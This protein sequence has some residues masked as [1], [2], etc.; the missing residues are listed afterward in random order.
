MRCKV[1]L[2]R[3]CAVWP[4]TSSTMR[5]IMVGEP[6]RSRSPILLRPPWTLL[7]TVSIMPI[8]GLWMDWSSRLVHSMVMRML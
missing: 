4:R 6:L 3:C 5:P 8:L 7:M 1:S 2:E